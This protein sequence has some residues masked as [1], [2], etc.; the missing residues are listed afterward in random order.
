MPFPTKPS[1][2][3]EDKVNVPNSL[4]N[5]LVW[6]L[7]GDVTE[8]TPVSLEWIPLASHSDRRL[9]YSL[10]HDLIHCTTGGRKKTPKHVALPLAVKHMTGSTKLVTFL[11]RLGYGLSATQVREIET[12]MSEDILLQQRDSTRV[13]VPSNITSSSFVHLAWDNNDLIEETLTG[14]DTTHCTNGIAI[15]RQ[16][17]I[18]Q[19]KELP[20]TVC[21][22][23]AAR[24][25]RAR[26][27]APPPQLDVE[28]VGAKCLGPPLL[29]IPGAI[30]HSYHQNQQVKDSIFSEDFAWLLA[31]LSTGDSASF[32]QQEMEQTTPGWSAFNASVAQSDVIQPSRISYLPVIPASPTELS[33]VHTL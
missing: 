32:G 20:G 23:P 24:R 2:V 16:V 8:C 1:D 21:V 6:V 18:A 9:V 27:I 4:F 10:A 33:T 19:S 11:N 30:L 5:V 12:G 3:T 26:S 7:L 14:L 15:Q 31:R 13:F 17:H 28:D 22:Q 29:P 25:R